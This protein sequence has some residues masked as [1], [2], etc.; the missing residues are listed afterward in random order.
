MIRVTALALVALV[1]ACQ[2]D[3]TL[4]GYGAAGVTWQLT[5]LAGEPFDARTTLNF[6]EP[7]QITGQGPCN[8]Y[9]TTMTVP[10]PWFEAGPIQSTKMACPDL[11]AETAFFQ[12]LA[13][14]TQSEILGDTLILRND[15][16]DELV[17][18]A[19]E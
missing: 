4:A 8:R 16:E 9:S 1:P 3:E 10:Y 6:P 13:T 17:F 2:A 19:S 7:G 11:A 18:K 5:E 14:M 15:A 12:A